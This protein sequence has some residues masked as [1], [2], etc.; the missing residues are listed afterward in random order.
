MDPNKAT[1]MVR[2]QRSLCTALGNGYRDGP[3]ASSRLVGSMDGRV[4][5]HCSQGHSGRGVVMVT[6]MMRCLHN[7]ER[8][9]VVIL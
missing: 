4:R 7:Q 8:F 2:D 5:N 3:G 6:L 9:A 1:P